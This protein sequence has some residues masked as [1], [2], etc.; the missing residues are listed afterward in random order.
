MTSNNLNGIY[1]IYNDGRNLN[2]IR[3]IYNDI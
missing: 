1:H 2:R 3:H